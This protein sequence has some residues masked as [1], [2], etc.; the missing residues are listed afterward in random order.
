MHGLMNFINNRRLL[1]IPKNQRFFD[2]NLNRPKRSVCALGRHMRI[3][4]SA[5][6]QFDEYEMIIFDDLSILNN[7]LKHAFSVACE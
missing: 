7:E 4:K 3:S 2:I 1:E 5:F 6:H